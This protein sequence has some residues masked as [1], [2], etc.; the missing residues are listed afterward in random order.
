MYVWLFFQWVNGFI[1]MIISKL[2]QKDVH[3]G[4]F[5][6]NSD[7]RISALS[8]ISLDK[9]T[10]LALGRLK[11]NTAKLSSVRISFVISCLDLISLD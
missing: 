10:N 7:P 6:M 4:K 9:M 1:T 8:Q 2:E 11:F 5:I 3:R